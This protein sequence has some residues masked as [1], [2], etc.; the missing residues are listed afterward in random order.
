MS[1][2]VRSK[3]DIFHISMK[4]NIISTAYCEIYD[5]LSAYGVVI[6]LKP[7]TDTQRR[8]VQKRALVVNMK[9]MC[10]QNG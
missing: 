7:A 2:F 4:E 1:I 10:K 5:I 3:N 8:R 6:T 9:V